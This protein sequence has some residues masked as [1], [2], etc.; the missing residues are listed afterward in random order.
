MS[1]AF[2]GEIRQ[3]AF[4]FVPYNWMLCDGRELL[5]QQYAPLY[6]LIGQ[7]YGGN[8]TTTFK[9]PNLQGCAALG[10]GQG[11]GLTLRN[12]GK[13]AGE[14]GVIAPLPAHT[15][16]LNGFSAGY[17]K[18]PS[19]NKQSPTAGVSYP[20]RYNDLTNT[21]APVSYLAYATAGQ[22]VAM[23]NVSLTPT[24][25]P[26]TLA[27]ENRQPYLALAFCICVTDGV[28]PPFDNS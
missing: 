25:A 10:Y 12:I 9:L 2:F 6:S 15:H 7:I 23:N 24:A 3:F 13:L 20:N 28:Y 11:P 26:T 22:T 8:G 17:L 19:A 21:S 1:D 18:A 14:E 5:V 16:S 4:G 27:H